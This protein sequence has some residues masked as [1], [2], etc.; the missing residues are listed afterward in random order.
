MSQQLRALVFFQKTRVQFPA[1][2]WQLITVYNSSS[3]GSIIIFIFFVFDKYVFNNSFRI[4][5]FIVALR[6][7][8]F[9]ILLSYHKYLVL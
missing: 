8:M 9:I 2:T 3:R 5:I 6:T 1:H 7:Y 4:V